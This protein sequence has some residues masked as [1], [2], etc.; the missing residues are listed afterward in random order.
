MV[1][2]TRMAETAR[3]T[4]VAT[5]VIVGVV[6]FVLA[7]WKLRLVVALLFAGFIIAA[8]IRPSIVALERRHVPRSAGLVLHYAV[9]AGLIALALWFAVPRA[10]DQVTGALE[11]LPQ[12]R[13]AIGVEAQQSS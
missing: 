13:H 4:F 11:N 7:L 5:L 6:V 8:A 2:R 10:L 1:T 3:N 9:F 12:T